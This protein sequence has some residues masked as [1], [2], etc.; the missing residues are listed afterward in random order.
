MYLCATARL[1]QAIKAIAEIRENIS[2]KERK[3][4]YSKHP[5]TFW[6]LY[7]FGHKLL[8]PILESLKTQIIRIGK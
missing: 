5:E 4:K 7:K 8:L 6:A 1:L 3:A 2:M